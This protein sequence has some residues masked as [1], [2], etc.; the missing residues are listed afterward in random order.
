MGAPQVPPPA[1]EE[2]TAL[3]RAA[4]KLQLPLVSGKGSAL[5]LFL[6]F[7]GAAAGVLL[8]GFTLHLP[9]WIDVEIMLALWW[10]VWIVALARLLFRGE[11]VSH[12]FNYGGPRGWFRAPRQ[13]ADWN[14]GGPVFVD[15]EGCAG[16]IGM[17][18]AVIA[19]IATAWLLIEVVIP[20]LAV[21]LYGLI[22]GMLAHVANDDH[23]CAGNFGLAMLW[24][25][26]WATL[27]TAPLALLTLVVHFM[28]TKP[29][30]V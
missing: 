9:A 13:S 28:V 21:L 2:T 19:I 17:I 12:D 16:I 20:V 10:V 1:P 5:V 15:L 6:C 22:R 14:W 30:A 27:Y 24:G 11:R 18:L 26:L 4:R 7:L 23:R 25:T 3:R 29:H 8:A